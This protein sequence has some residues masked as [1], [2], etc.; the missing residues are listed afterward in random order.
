MSRLIWWL[1]VHNLPEVCPSRG[2][3]TAA[4]KEAAEK[5]FE[6]ARSSPQALK[7]EYI[8]SS[9]AARLEVVPFPSP[10]ESDFFRNL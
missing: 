4:A 8:F 5:L 3:L 9:L 7:R 1:R 6:G 2:N 10:G